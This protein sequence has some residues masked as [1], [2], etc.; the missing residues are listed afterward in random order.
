MARH[1]CPHEGYEIETIW[2]EQCWAEQQRDRL[3]AQSERSND[4]KQQELELR[5]AYLDSDTSRP[6]WRP[7]PRPVRYVPLPVVQEQPKR[8]GGMNV[9]PE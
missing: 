1:F 5:T 7:T 3:V 8:G 9:E 6:E 2:C 4:L